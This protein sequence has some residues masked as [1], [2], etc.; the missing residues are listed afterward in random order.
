MNTEGYLIT[1]RPAGA[2][3][4]FDVILPVGIDVVVRATADVGVK[5]IEAAGKKLRQSS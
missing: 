5:T 2:G 4:V 3:E 1:C